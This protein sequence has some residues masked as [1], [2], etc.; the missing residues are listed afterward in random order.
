MAAAA[1]APDLATLEKLPPAEAGAIILAGREHGP[2]ETIIASTPPPI[3]PGVVEREL[4]EQAV[5]GPEGCVRQ[6][7][8]AT[9]YY[10]LDGDQNATRASLEGGA[11]FASAYKSTE[12]ALLSASGCAAARY[13]RLNRGIDASAGLA[14]LKH[15]DAIGR[16]KTK[17]RFTCSGEVEKEFCGSAATARRALAKI[18]PWAVMRKDARI[19][20]WLGNPGSTVTIISYDEA[21]PDRISVERKIPS[22]A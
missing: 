21:T 18:S 9:F 12:I 17:A 19:M 10:R 22:P 1:T 3:P 2:I 13:A 8:T 4:I 20:L 7:W 16:G 6:R 5:S 11:T 15:L 14:A